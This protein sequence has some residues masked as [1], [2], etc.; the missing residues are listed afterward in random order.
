MQGG[1]VHRTLFDP[2]TCGVMDPAFVAAYLQVADQN[3]QLANFHGQAWAPHDSASSLQEPA[4]LQPVP[5]RGLAAGAPSS[6]SNYGHGH[7]G[8]GTAA[9]GLPAMVVR[10]YRSLKLFLKLGLLE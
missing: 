3:Q 9:D 1:A 4:W 2:A 8:S 5:Q 7:D 10:I 6:L